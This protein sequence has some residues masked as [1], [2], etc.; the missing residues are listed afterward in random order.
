MSRAE[1]LG[2]GKILDFVPKNGHQRSRMVG[3]DCARMGRVVIPRYFDVDWHPVKRELENTVLLPILGDQYGRVL[4]NGEL[5]LAFEEGAFRLIYYERTLP[6][7]PRTSRPILQ[8]ARDRIA[9]RGE[10]LPPELESIITALDHLPE[11]TETDPERIKSGSREKEIIKTRLLAAEEM[12][13]V[14]SRSMKL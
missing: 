11:R 12:P 14:R 4:E 9:R 13:L 10:P 1:R 7:A 3:M 6:L 2:L 5:K 8:Q